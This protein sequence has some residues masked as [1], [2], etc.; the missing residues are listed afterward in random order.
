MAKPLPPMNPL[1]AA[2]VRTGIIVLIFLMLLLGPQTD[3]SVSGR[4][5]VFFS[6]FSLIVVLVIMLIYEGISAAISS[7]K[8]LAASI[9]LFMLSLALT[10]VAYIGFYFLLSKVPDVFLRGTSIP[11]VVITQFAA[12]LQLCL[13]FFSISRYAPQEA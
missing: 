9:I 13:T 1:K 4:E 3:M 2:I 12:T 8:T 6:G 10:A 7:L 5:L 11:S